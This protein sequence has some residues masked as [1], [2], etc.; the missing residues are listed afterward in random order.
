MTDT[1]MNR[2]NKAK[3]IGTKWTRLTPQ[4]SEKHFMVLKWDPE[5]ENS[6]EHIMLEAVLTRRSQSI[7]VTALRDSEQWRMGWH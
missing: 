3:L 6:R 7:S 5:H 4:G 2:F 1:S